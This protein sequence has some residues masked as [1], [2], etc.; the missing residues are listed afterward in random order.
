MTEARQTQ[1][2]AVFNFL[3]ANMS[4]CKGITD[5]QAVDMFGAYRLSD[6]IFRLRKKLKD[7]EYDIVNIW[8]TCTD[9]YG[10]E[11]RYVEYVMVKK[12]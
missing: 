9:R 10:R 6:I 2:G 4:K 8:H 12:Q 7:T 1:T 3:R 5:K 11:T